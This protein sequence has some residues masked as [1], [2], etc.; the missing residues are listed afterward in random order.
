MSIEKI[1]QD[2]IQLIKADLQ[3]IQTTMESEGALDS[4]QASKLT[5]YTKT[6]II[7]S[8]NEREITKLEGLN[9]VSDDELEEL[10]KQALESLGDKND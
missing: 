6:L 1:L 7:A 9:S 10:A 4:K 8:K 5:D 2:A 3:T